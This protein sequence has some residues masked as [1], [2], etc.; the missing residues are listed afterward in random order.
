M[1]PLLFKIPLFG[2]IAVHTYGVMVALGFLA[3]LFWVTRESKRLGQSPAKAMDLMFYII[4][5]AI[6]G[7]RVLHVL[8][9]ERGRFFEDPLML[10]KVWE[11][12]LVFYGGLI[13]S[14]VVSVW[15]VKRNKMP[16]FL[17]CD[18]FAPAIAL[19][20]AIGRLG[21]FFAGCCYGRVVDHATWYTLVFPSGVNSFAPTGIPL[22]STQLGESFGELF[23]FCL[24]VVFRKYKKFDG[25]L[26]SMYLMFYAVLRYSI[27]FFRGDTDRGFVIEPWLSTSQFISLVIFVL[28]LSLYLI[29]RKAKQN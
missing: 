7:S 21:C 14:L 29:R 15:Y 16:L 23:I 6:V 5:S 28:G 1:Y 12:G 4:L 2:G 13:V 22:Y 19:G 10:F 8:V 25:Q 26:I 24:L 9:S 27:E 18:V 3:G 17:M 11:G 20:H